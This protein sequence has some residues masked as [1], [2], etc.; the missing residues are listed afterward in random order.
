MNNYIDELK[1]AKS[2]FDNKTYRQTIARAYVLH[3]KGKHKS[4]QRILD[5]VNFFLN[6]EGL[7]PVS[8]GFIRRILEK[9][10]L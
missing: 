7:K 4:K 6:A 10:K 2:F 9:E 8:Y 3:L 5:E 1:K